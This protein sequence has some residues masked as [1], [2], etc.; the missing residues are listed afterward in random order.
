MRFYDADNPFGA[1]IPDFTTDCPSLQKEPV[2]HPQT[3]PLDCCAPHGVEWVAD[4]LDLHG[5]VDP[6]HAKRAAAALRGAAEL[7]KEQ[8]ASGGSDVLKDIA[9]T[10]HEMVAGSTAPAQPSTA[11]GEPPPY[12]IP[13]DVPG[14]YFLRDGAIVVGQDGRWARWTPG[15]AFRA[16]GAAVGVMR[17][18]PGAAK[19]L[20]TLAEAAEA[21]ALL[22][23][24][25]GE[26]IFWDEKAK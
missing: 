7:L 26:S 8:E 14:F 2:I 9:Q 18:A 20:D 4:Q 19:A 1:E 10:L 6:K 11:A 21:V 23:K 12:G 16:V 5:R 24:L 15:D 3:H 22:T 13:A 25:V 17:V